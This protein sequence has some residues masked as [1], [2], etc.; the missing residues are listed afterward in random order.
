MR[1]LDSAALAPSTGMDLRLDHPDRAAEA[2]RRI[3]RLGNAEARHAARHR[4]TKA[5]QDVLALVFVDFHWT[6]LACLPCRRCHRA[7][8]HGPSAPLLCARGEASDLSRGWVR[9]LRN[10]VAGQDAPDHVV[11]EAA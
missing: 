9:N 11:R 3:H 6:I 10:S 8:G 7:P 2:A 1:Y 5:P 4:H